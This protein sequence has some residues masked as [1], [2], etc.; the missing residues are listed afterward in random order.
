[1]CNCYLGSSLD[2]LALRAR[3]TSIPGSQRT[4]INRDSCWPATTLMAQQ[5]TKDT[6]AQYF[7]KKGP[8]A[9]LQS[10]SLKGGLLFKHTS[11]GPLRS[12][13]ET[14]DAHLLPLLQSSY[15]PQ[16]SLYMC[17]MPQVLYQAPGLCGCCLENTFYLVGPGG[18]WDLCSL[19]KWDSQM[20][21]QFLAAYHTHST[22]SRLKRPSNIC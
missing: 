13:P 22:G 18:Q 11:K 3:R 7:S 4:A 9:Y 15:L 10:F 2:H 1:M 5:G 21:R 6:G 14:S 16:R 12:S 8:L 20:E 17:L 19:V